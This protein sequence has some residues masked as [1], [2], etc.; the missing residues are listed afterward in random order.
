LRIG[1]TAITELSSQT[2]LYTTLELAHRTGTAAAAVGTVPGLFHFALGSGSYAQT[3]ARVGMELDHKVNESL[4]FSA[5]AHL[6]S[7]GRDPSVAGSLGLKAT[8]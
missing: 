2:S 7:N 6:A 5:S 8:F 1:L 4:S 3:W